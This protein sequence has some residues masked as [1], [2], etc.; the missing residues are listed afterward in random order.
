M[1]YIL[2]IVLI[3]SAFIGFTQ[4]KIIKTT[5]DTINCK[6]SEILSGELKYYYADNPKIVFGIDKALVDYIEFSTGEI[7]K[8]DGNSFDNKDYYANQKTHALKINF[9]SPLLGST[10]LVYEQNIKPGKSW[11]TALGI[12]GI[13]F[14]SYD[15]NSK[16]IYGKIAYKFLRTPF[17]YTQ[18]MHYAHIL[19]GGYIAPE[20][21]F[22]YVKYDDFYD[23][24]NGNSSVDK[25]EN[26]AVAIT[27]KFGKQWVFDDAF[28]VDSFFGIGYGYNKNDLETIPYGFVSMDNEFPLAFTAGIRLGWAF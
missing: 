18:K 3:F 21:A 8:M 9:L 17:Y 15:L 1:K 27:L 5:G 10:E 6:V 23:Y 25:E 12:I 20:L 24:W 19:K 11:E 14:D 26:M 7:I 28:I 4:D 13:G 16:G 2:S 22:R